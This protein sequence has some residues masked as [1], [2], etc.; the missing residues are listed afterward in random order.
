MDWLYSLD[1]AAFRFINITL[2][3]PLMDGV[4]P[5]FSDN[6]FFVPI[7][8]VL[9][10]ALLWKGGARGR[11]FVLMLLLVVSIGDGWVCN[12]IKDA[13]QR[14]RPFNVVANAHVLIGKGGSGSFPS[15]HAANW[16]SATMVAYI[17]YRRSWRFMLPLA[18]LVSFSRV[19][20]GVHYPSDV[21]AGAILGAGYG[22]AIVL[23]VNAL[24]QKIGRRWFPLWWEKLSSLVNPEVRH[25]ISTPRRDEL[26]ESLTSSAGAGGQN[27]G[28]GTRVTRPSEGELGTC[29]TRPSEGVLRQSPVTREQHYVHLGYAIIVVLLLAR[30]AYLASGKIELSEDEAYQWTWSK[31]LALSYYSKPPMIACM[32]W[33]GTHL[34]GDTEFGVRFFSPIISAIL[35]LLTLRFLAREANARAAL[36]A[37]I[38][39]NC[40]PILAAGSILMT[41]DPLLILFWTAAMYMGWR[42]VQPTGTTAQ[43]CWAGLWLGL[44]FLSKYAALYQ[45]IC[46]IV[47]FSL[48]KPA[49]AHLRKPGP[50]LALIIILLCTLPVLVWNAQHDW[51]TIKHVGDNAGRSKDSPWEP[52]LKYFIDFFAEQA[53]MQNPVFLIASIWA[54]IVFW[55][56]ERQNP[57]L[58]FFFSMGAPIFLGYML[59]S[60]YKR[61][62]PNWIAPSILPLFCLAVI[63][64]EARWRGGSRVIKGWFIAGII[65]GLTIIIV[66]HDT[67]LVGKVLKKDLPESMDISR[68]VRAWSEMATTIGDLREK[69]EGEGKTTFII[70]GHYGLTGEISFYLPEAKTAVIKKEPLVYFQSSDTPKNQFYFWPEYNYRIHRKGQDAI[71]VEEIDLRRPQKTYYTTLLQQE[72]A[73]VE[74]L[75][76]RDIVYRGRL[77]RRLQFY[78]CHDLK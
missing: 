41:I 30:L 32:Q 45:V 16:F 47:F 27:E 56:R 22:V 69:L 68:R 38:V 62:F 42:A 51:I 40:A 66:G 75:G 58:L 23:G 25:E 53:L 67:N 8:I 15:S 21:L 5:F 55:K 39:L 11:I 64:W 54:M 65:L 49:R 20:N 59:F 37:V 35:S 26:H 6:K 48:W 12:T 9:A 31:H 50:Y 44:S 57:L 78:L 2:S 70:A 63:Y 3:N 52:T 72:F 29:V 19:Y 33:L 4:M 36:S 77:F 14:P 76:T 17:F 18:F 61:I 28:S 24:W 10:L 71:F 43:W 34:W 73:S 46:W 7:V 74:D 13:L 1:L 60:F